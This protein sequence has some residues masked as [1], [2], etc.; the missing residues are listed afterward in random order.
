MKMSQ[1]FLKLIQIY[2]RTIKR[3][4]KGIVANTTIDKQLEEYLDEVKGSQSD[5]TY[6]RKSS[7]MKYFNEYWEGKEG[8]KYWK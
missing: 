6:K 1:S 5:V 8:D 2:R 4:I 3:T 7:S